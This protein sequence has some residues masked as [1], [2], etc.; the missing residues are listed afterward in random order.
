MVARSS[1]VNSAGIDTPE[2]LISWVQT[3]HGHPIASHQDE[4]RAEETELKTDMRGLKLG[5]KEMGLR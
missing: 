4:H 1:V 5:A 3:N 2:L